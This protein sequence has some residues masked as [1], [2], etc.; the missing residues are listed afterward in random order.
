[1]DTHYSRG[2]RVIG[3]IRF[4]EDDTGLRYT[5]RLL[6]NDSAR[7]YAMAVREAG[8]DEVSLEVLL[9]EASDR[10]LDKGAVIHKRV[11]RSGGPCRRALWRLCRRHY[12]CTR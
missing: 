1:M 7:D 10:R 2:G 8:S 5:G 4:A 3:G 6:D 11:R 9:G 12:R